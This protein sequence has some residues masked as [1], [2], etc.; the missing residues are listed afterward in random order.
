[1]ITRGEGNF[2]VDREGVVDG[3]SFII[4][5]YL[6]HRK[7]VE[8]EVRY[9]NA[10]DA[11]AAFEGRLKERMEK[12]KLQRERLGPSPVLVTKADVERFVESC[13]IASS[14]LERIRKII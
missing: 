8:T 5:Y 14:S 1:M 7:P 6:K 2:F 10:T 12:A 11:I 3:D 4:R 9:P 13:G